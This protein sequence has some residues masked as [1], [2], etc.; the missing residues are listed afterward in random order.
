MTIKLSLSIHTEY[1]PDESADG[2]ESAETTKF[3]V[4]ELPRGRA[5][6]SAQ[7]IR[8]GFDKIAQ[9][10]ASLNVQATLVSH[11]LHKPEGD[12]V[13]DAEA[14]FARAKAEMTAALQEHLL[15][16]G[17]ATAEQLGLA[18]PDGLVN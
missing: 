14:A 3:F 11:T 6:D 10:I 12:V 9:D 4:G 18:V 7:I 15:K 13:L 1:T 5:M 16:S 17:A 2:K 8:E